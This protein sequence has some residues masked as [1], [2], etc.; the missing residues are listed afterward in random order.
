M[1]THTCE[2]GRPEPGTAVNDTDTASLAVDPTDK[3][4]LDHERRA[5]RAAIDEHHYDMCPRGVRERAQQIR[6]ATRA[7]AA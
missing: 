5:R 4:R 3:W 1:T 7:G 6:A 2:D